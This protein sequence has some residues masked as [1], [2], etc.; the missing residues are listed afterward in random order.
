MVGT[1]TLRKA[2]RAKQFLARAQKALGHPIE[3]ISGREEARLIYAGV[4]H[5]QPSDEPRLVVDIGGRSTELI[6]GHGQTPR[7][8]ESFQIG[9]VSLSERYFPGGR[10]TEQAFRQAQ[11]AAG[12][13]VAM[14][15]AEVTPDEVDRLVA[16]IKSL[17]ATAPGAGS[18]GQRSRRGSVRQLQQGDTGARHRLPHRNAHHTDRAAL[19]GGGPTHGLSYR[20]CLIRRFQDQRRRNSFRSLPS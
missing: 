4:A 7:L 14:P 11:V 15:K 16:Y 18:T 9:S 3:V 5:L 6:L 12:Y 1:N 8:A 19:A 13:P 2:K 20:R 10:Y 17:G